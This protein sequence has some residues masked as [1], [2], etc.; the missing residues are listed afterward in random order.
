MG[1]QV[2]QGEWA[3]MVMTGI[4]YWGRMGSQVEVS[5]EGPRGL[6]YMECFVPGGVEV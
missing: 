2:C 3:Q 6:V 5:L 1:I 4:V